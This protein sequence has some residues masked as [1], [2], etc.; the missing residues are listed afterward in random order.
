MLIEEQK[1]EQK[2]ETNENTVVMQVTYKDV[3]GYDRCS[4]S[5]IKY[6]QRHDIIQRMALDKCRYLLGEK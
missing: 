2:E 3:L 6:L 4:I 5:E 1:E